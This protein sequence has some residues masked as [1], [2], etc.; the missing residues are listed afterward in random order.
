MRWTETLSVKFPA[1]AGSR[2]DDY[3]NARRAKDIVGLIL[4]QTKI[5]CREKTLSDV[6]N[7]GLD[8]TTP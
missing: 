5:R 4:D 2:D 7:A 1:Q 3:R 8:P 6:E